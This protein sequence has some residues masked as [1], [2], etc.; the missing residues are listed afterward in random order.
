M[1]F[2]ENIMIFICGVYFF[3]FF[4]SS[5]PQTPP[6]YVAMRNHSS[7]TQG[8]KAD[9]FT[10]FKNTNYLVIM[11]VFSLMYCVYAGFGIF[12][13]NLLH[14][15]FDSA[16]NIAGIACVF[17]LCGSIAAWRAGH[18][19]DKT[20]KYLFIFRAIL[21]FST[22]VMA[23]SL[24]LFPTQNSYLGYLWGILGGFFIVPIVPVTY[25]FITETTHPLAPALVLNTTLITA[26]I[27][28]T[29]YDAI[30][31]TIVANNKQQQEK[32]AIYILISMVIISV[33]SLGL[34]FFVKEDLR[35]HGAPDPMI[36]IQTKSVSSN[37]T[38]KLIQE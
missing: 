27:V 14:P 7:I 2:V 31:L 3:A 11:T 30:C 15:F 10:L 33:I 22:T 8:F 13:A 5:R 12:V 34:S 35:R 9:L 36:T 26:N 21:I 18:L 23:L 20:G 24:V 37:S 25:N 38:E 4:R 17:V 6:S 29:I 32:G 1:L 16:V 19:L 28:L